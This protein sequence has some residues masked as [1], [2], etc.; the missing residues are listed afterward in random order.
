MLFRVL[1]RHDFEL[2]FPDIAA[3]NPESRRKPGHW[4]RFDR[5]RGLTGRDSIRGDMGRPDKQTSFKGW[6]PFLRKKDLS[7]R[8]PS[9]LIAL[10]NRE[11][12]YHLVFAIVSSNYIS[13]FPRYRKRH[14]RKRDSDHFSKSL[15][16]ER[17][18]RNRTMQ[19][20]SSPFT[21]SSLSEILTTAFFPVRILTFLTSSLAKHQ[22]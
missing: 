17:Y 14:R 1:P 18:D 8:S 7:G 15:N 4:I 19:I 22:F 3:G 21:F 2:R 11:T 13:L 6:A 5:L 12:D 10:S 9:K 16:C 20:F